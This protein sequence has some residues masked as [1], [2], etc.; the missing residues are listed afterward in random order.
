MG[1]MNLYE[2]GLQNKNAFLN[3]YK[4]NDV[5]YKQALSLW[6]KLDSACIYFLLIAIGVGVIIAIYY[7]YDYN[8]RPGRRYR[9]SRWLIWLGISALVTFVLTMV[10]GNIIVKSNISEVQSFLVT[11]SL[12][13]SLYSVITYFVI[14]FIICNIPVPTNAYRFLK[15]GK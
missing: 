3:G 2:W 13:N 11:I 8:R 7:Y 12:I 1:M 4:D 14:S 6:S 5:L 10:L 9:I 15:I